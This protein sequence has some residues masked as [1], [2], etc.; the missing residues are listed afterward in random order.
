MIFVLFRI[1]SRFNLFH[2]KRSHYNSVINQHN[3]INSA[4]SLLQFPTLL[5]SQ[6]IPPNSDNKICFFIIYCPFYGHEPLHR[7]VA[8]IFGQP[9]DK[10]AWPF[11]H[12]V[13]RGHFLDLELQG[14]EQ[15]KEKKSIKFQIY[16]SR[17]NRTLFLMNIRRVNSSL[18][19]IRRGLNNPTQ[20]WRD[21]I[22]Y[23][24]CEVVLGNLW[25]QGVGQSFLDSWKLS[26]FLIVGT[27]FHLQ[28]RQFSEGQ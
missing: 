9:G 4:I 5:R 6:I 20:R 10:H 25:T 15:R 18:G 14:A 1:Y 3:Q 2:N 8:P 17:R 21:L 7:G 13:P 19:K 24:S 23:H 28:T 26:L 12:C 16:V 11:S 27:E 22:N